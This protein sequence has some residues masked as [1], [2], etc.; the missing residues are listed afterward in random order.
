M[1]QR[2]EPAAATAKPW[3]VGNLSSFPDNARKV[4]EGDGFSNRL[5]AV[6]DTAE[7]AANAVATYNAA[8]LRPV[9]D[10]ALQLNYAPFSAE[11][12]QKLL[13]DLQTALSIQG[14]RFALGTVVDPAPVD[15]SLRAQHDSIC[16]AP[17]IAPFTDAQIKHMV[18]RF[19]QWEFPYDFAPDGGIRFEPSSGDDAFDRPIG[20]NLF[21]SSE[22]ELM[23]RHMLVGLPSKQPISADAATT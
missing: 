11:Q 18:E 3:F 15:I 16:G 19:L 17:A 23:I 12:V 9:P 22:A 8:R 5:V 13:R 14:L 7:D 20:A 2:A 6:F 4:F 1:A 21:T 10:L